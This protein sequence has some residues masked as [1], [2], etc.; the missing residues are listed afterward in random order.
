MLKLP[1][2]QVKNKRSKKNKSE[3]FEMKQDDAMD[4]DYLDEEDYMKDDYKDEDSDDYDDEDYKMPG[5]KKGRKM[6]STEIKRRR[7]NQNGKAY[8]RQVKEECKPDPNAP[9]SSE[10]EDC[11]SAFQEV[12]DLFANEGENDTICFK[13]QR[14]QI[15]NDHL[16]MCKE[17]NVS[18]RNIRRTYNKLICK[19]PSV[20][21]F[22]MLVK[23]TEGNCYDCRPIVGN[24]M[25]KRQVIKD[26]PKVYDILKP[27]LGLSDEDLY[28]GSRL[29][30]KCKFHVYHID[31]D[32]RRRLRKTYEPMKA[33][34]L[35][36]IEADMER[37]FEEVVKRPKPRLASSIPPS[38]NIELTLNRDLDFEECDNVLL[39]HWGYWANELRCY[40]FNV[41]DL[42]LW[43]MLLWDMWG[44]YV[45][46]ILLSSRSINQ[47][48]FVLYEQNEIL[49]KIKSIFQEAGEKG[50]PDL[51]C[52]KDKDKNNKVCPE[53]GKI[54]PYKTNREK[55]LFYH[56]MRDH[57][58]Q[59]YKCD[60]NLEFKSLNHKKNHFMVKH[61]GKAFVMC[62]HCN[63]AVLEENMQSHVERYH[64]KTIVC[65]LCGYNTNELKRY[66]YHQ[67][68]HHTPVACQECGKTFV[69][70]SKL[71]SHKLHDH[72]HMLKCD[73]C[74]SEFKTVPAL[75]NHKKRVHVDDKDKA[76][77]CQLCGKGFIDAR[78][79][80]VHMTNMHI[81]D[82]PHECRFGCGMRYNDRSNMRAHEKK[83]HGGLGVAQPM[84][85]AE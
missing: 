56:H 38:T 4:Q 71:K 73:L 44:F 34:E 37:K 42:T 58:Y 75:T 48:F 84:K 17:E 78:P 24:K 25:E 31:Y 60:C 2:L 76:F 49:K 74:S 67:A 11:E 29:L 26:F 18:R 10:D 5:G 65:D 51:S 7:R 47:S 50:L 43:P 27:L 85:T 59:N 64:N 35:K 19:K 6:S 30:K 69:G 13:T 83:K 45:D 16:E 9:A 40:T 80:R 36:K 32:F 39:L 12:Y 41:E 63:H 46:N 8:Y 20:C 52:T 3:E 28:L 23:Q 33:E 66:Y 22:L 57:E 68:Q 1:F 21:M 55:T 14:H 54:L 62:E 77:I 70:R 15:N 81:K 72:I 61:S 53:C 79:L 82:R